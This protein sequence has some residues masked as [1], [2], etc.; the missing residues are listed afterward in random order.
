[1]CR[2]IVL[3]SQ[4]LV[5]SLTTPFRLTGLFWCAT[6]CAILLRQRKY[7]LFFFLLAPIG[8]SQSLSPSLNALIWR[9]PLQAEQSVSIREFLNILVRPLC[10]HQYGPP[11]FFLFCFSDSLAVQQSFYSWTWLEP[12][13][14]TICPVNEISLLRVKLF[15]S[16]SLSNCTMQS[17]HIYNLL[18]AV[19]CR[20]TLW[21]RRFYFINKT[22]CPNKNHS[23]YGF[24]CCPS[25]DAFN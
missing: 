8:R 11:L 25:T 23:T 5:V 9:S 17:F 16:S 13:S 3:I 14:P 15:L 1:M 22:C 19:A 20:S 21:P 12:F 2:Q 18:L 10:C 24:F 6:S 7:K 4:R